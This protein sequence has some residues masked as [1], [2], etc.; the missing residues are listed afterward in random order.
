MHACVCLAS[1]LA[2]RHQV[3]TNQRYTHACIFRTSERE[4]L[5]LNMKLALPHR[6]RQLVSGAVRSFS[7]QV[8]SCGAPATVNGATSF[9][10]CDHLL[11][12]TLQKFLEPSSVL[13]RRWKETLPMMIDRP[14]VIRSTSIPVPRFWKR[15]AVGVS[16]G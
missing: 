2:C 12:P 14:S 8:S 4:L 11:L 1:Q 9:Q 5:N 16:S 13:P 6:W 7:L 3:H 10:S 15:T